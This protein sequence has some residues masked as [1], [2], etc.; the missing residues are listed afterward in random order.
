MPRKK[1]TE[2]EKEQRR[3]ER[4]AKKAAEEA[5][6]QKLLKKKTIHDEIWAIVILAV[7][8]FL[9]LSLFTHTTGVVG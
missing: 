3:I 1:L 8:V 7:G 2:E 6:A 9:A 4:E 5:E